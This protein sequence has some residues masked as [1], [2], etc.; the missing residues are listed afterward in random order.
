MVTGAVVT[1]CRRQKVLKEDKE[2]AGNGSQ[3]RQC[4]KGHKCSFRHDD[5]KLAKPTPKPLHPLNHEHNEVEV[6]RRKITSE[7]GVR[8]GSLLDSRAKTA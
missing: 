5:D 6:R 7:A 3:K 4:L 2:N 8:L 1:S